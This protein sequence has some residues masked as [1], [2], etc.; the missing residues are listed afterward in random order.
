MDISNNTGGKS[1][2]GI[3]LIAALAGFIFRF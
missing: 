2:F 3:S 1:L